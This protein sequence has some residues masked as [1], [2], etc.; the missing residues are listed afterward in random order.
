MVLQWWMEVIAIAGEGGGYF[1]WPVEA[2]L[3]IECDPGLGVQ[4][5]GGE[6]AFNSDVCHVSGLHEALCTGS[7]GIVSNSN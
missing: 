7:P 1:T 5:P 4:V 3:A 2:F 6:S